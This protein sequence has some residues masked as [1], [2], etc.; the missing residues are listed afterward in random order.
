MNEEL[1]DESKIYR[2]NHF[3]RYLMTKYGS[4][5]HKVNINAGFTCPNKDE[6]NKGGCIFCDNRAFNKYAY[7]EL[8][9]SIHQQ[10]TE[11]IQRKKKIYGV[12]KIIAYFQAYTNTYDKIE[13]LRMRYDIIRD[14]PEIIGLAIGTRPDCIDSEKL[15]LIES[16][17]QD[18]HVWIEYGLQS[19]CDETLV[20]IN[21]GH[22][23]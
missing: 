1:F 17:A 22:N 8:K 15:D 13:N 9:E 4:R 19:A 7:P 20:N 10:L 12:D 3:G 6:E 21:R 5:I 23:F 16:Y 11:G 2:Y 14:F 18:Y